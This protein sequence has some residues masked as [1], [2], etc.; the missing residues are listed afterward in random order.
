MDATDI[1]GL[2]SQMELRLIDSLKRNLSEH[3]AWEGDLQT[4]WPA[5]QA[6]KIR[7]LEKYRKDKQGIIGE[8]SRIIDNETQSLLHD[9]FAE[10][11]GRIGGDEGFFGIWDEKVG[12]LISEVQG[13]ERT[14][15]NAALRMMDDAYRSTMTRAEIAVSTGSVSV[16]QA[17]EMALDDFAKKGLN[18]IEYKN[19][20][21][22]NI[23]D[24]IFMALNTAGTRAALMG[25]AKQRA[26]L[27]IDTVRVSSYGGCSPT[28]LPWQGKIYID[29][30]FGVFNGQTY[31]QKGK[32][33]DGNWYLLLSAAVSEGLFHPNCRHTLTTYFPGAPQPPDMDEKAIKEHYALEQKQRAI[34]RRIRMWNRRC[35]GASDPEAKAAFTRK[36]QES[37][38]E[39][40]AFVKEHNDIL[41]RD[42]WREV[43][44]DVDLNRLD[45]NKSLQISEKS[46]I[47]SKTRQKLKMAKVE[48][49]PTET[50]K[51]DL[52]ENEIIGRLGGGDTT[53][54]SCSSLAFAYT[55]NKSKL[56]VLD[57]RGGISTLTFSSNAA[58]NEIATLPGVNGT[59]LK[60]Y[61]DFT[62]VNE[63]LKTIE[64]GKEYY[65]GSGQHA[66]I[67]RKTETGFEYLEL[68]SATNNRFKKLTTD[69]LQRRF[70]CK[71]SHT[72][73]GIK[74]QASNQLIECE[75]LGKNNE[76]KK[77]LGYINTSKES[78]KKGVSG[79]VK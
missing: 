36:L 5:W 75:S 76:F 11:E 35:A 74:M 63:L 28:C 60:E 19:G 31:D 50:F 58:I 57:F 14:V 51:A 59:V 17:V 23:A 62:A 70:G 43:P 71:R 21:R 53:T 65:L 29:D 20:A 4:K 33:S 13:S 68:Q 39:L 54:G 61:N 78:Q 25:G 6:L 64:S 73:S 79:S 27:G 10:G 56:N 37:R 2:F 77:L 44:R 7:S 48:Y 9:Q 52:L 15:Q 66:A 8:Y 30:V 38:A 18:C 24:Y 40:K 72:C 32:S 26:T 3:R 1:S 41:R 69:V 67:V 45:G 34:E 12:S 55:G 42:P 49:I 22:V 16:K 47:I 46:D